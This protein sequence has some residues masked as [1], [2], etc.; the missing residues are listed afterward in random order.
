MARRGSSRFKGPGAVGPSRS[1]AKL[2]RAQ[3]RVLQEGASR[4]LVDELLRVLPAAAPVYQ[5]NRVAP[6]RPSGARRAI[7]SLYKQA[8]GLTTSGRGPSTRVRLLEADPRRLF[9]V[10]RAERK[11]VMFALKVAGKRGVGRGKRWKR[12]YNSQWRC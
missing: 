2:P 10:R 12:T 3:E 5:V 7:L 6:R 11:Q 9:C 1:L 4:R 8:A